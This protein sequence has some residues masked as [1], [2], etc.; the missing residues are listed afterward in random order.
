ML[1]ASVLKRWLVLDNRQMAVDTP[2]NNTRA[3]MISTSE[4]PPGENWRLGFIRWRLED[5]PYN[6]VEK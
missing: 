1:V 3:R 5:M 6:R 4:N 2:A